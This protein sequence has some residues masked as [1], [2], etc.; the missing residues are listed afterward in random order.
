MALPSVASNV[1]R[2]GTGG[3]YDRGGA[4]GEAAK[5]LIDCSDAAIVSADSCD[6]IH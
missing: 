3:G 2:P 4:A 5:I 6:R 1:S